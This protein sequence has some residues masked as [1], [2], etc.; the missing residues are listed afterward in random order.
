M[1]SME[2]TLPLLP[3]PTPRPEKEKR[4]A[5]D[6]APVE[7]ASQPATGVARPPAAKGEKPPPA[8]GVGPREIG[9]IYNVG[10]LLYLCCC[11]VMDT[12]DPIR[13]E[14]MAI[15]GLPVLIRRLF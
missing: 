2:R 1:Q 7:C 11:W 13:G 6:Q 5:D 9:S 14:G 4:P 15:I 3:P 12:G 8:T 10:A